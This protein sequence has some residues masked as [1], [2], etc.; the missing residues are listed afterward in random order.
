[1]N[2]RFEQ[3]RP[4]IGAFLIA[5][6]A[7]YFSDLIEPFTKPLAASTLTF[8][9]V[10]AGFTATQRNMLLGMGGSRVIEFAVK[11]NNHRHILN[12]NWQCVAGGLSV[13][14]VSFIYLLLPC[15]PE[16]TDIVWKGWL[17]LWTG[18]IT[19]TLL[20]LLR[21]EWIMRRIVMRWLEE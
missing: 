4:Y 1:M 21:N 7:A 6:V 17:A 14:A 9:M 11:T 20:A 18:S 2:R 12:Y 15:P 16:R 19:L 8:G 13:V 3:F 10:V 5:F